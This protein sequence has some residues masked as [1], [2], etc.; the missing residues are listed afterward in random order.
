MFE[1]PALMVVVIYVAR[2][3]KKGSKQMAASHE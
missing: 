3:E 2:P 1:M